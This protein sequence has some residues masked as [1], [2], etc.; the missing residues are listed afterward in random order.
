MTIWIV[1]GV[2]L[3][4]AAY[5]VAW[6]WGGRTER[7]AAA[8]MLLHFAVAAMSIIYM[9]ER[10]GIDLPRKIDDSVRLLV[11]V[12]ICFRS[13]RWWPFLMTAGLALMVLVDVVVVLDPAVSRV[14][15]VSAQVGLGYL[16]DLTLLFSV[17]ERRLAG[18]EPA[19][20]A[21]WARAAM[22]TS[23]RR[24]RNRPTRRLLAGRPGERTEALP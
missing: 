20:R 14:G 5:A 11:F 6:F 16:V 13:D 19:G 7:L 1:L 12:W 2:C 17:C 15:A 21:A 4:M 23:A 9:W 24:N 3:G 22:A 18:E 10:N 8:V